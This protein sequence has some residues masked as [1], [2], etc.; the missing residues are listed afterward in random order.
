ML[1]ALIPPQF[2]IG[3]YVVAGV[4]IVAAGFWIY[5]TIY[6]RGYQAASVIYEQK[7]AAQKA[8]NDKAI[9]TAEKDMR[10]DMQVLALQKEKLENEIDR[11]NAEAA[12]DP[13]AANGGIK[14]GG[15]QRINSIR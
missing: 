3:V 6:D 13:D 5:D 7:Q 9:A 4:A 8:A 2:L 14:R 10:E 12:A 1:K 15:V 11:L